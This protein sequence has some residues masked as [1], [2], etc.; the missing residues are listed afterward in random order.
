MFLKQKKDGKI[1]GLTVAGG[2]KHRDYI[3][4]EDSISSTVAIESVLIS[5]IV[6]AKEDRNVALIDI[7]NAFIQT[8]LEHEKDM[9]IIKMRGILL[10]ILLDIAPD[11]Y[12]TYVTTYRSGIN[13]LITPFK[14]PF[15]EPW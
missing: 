5:F 7:P 6:D 9:A 10:G 13:Q 15:M 1:K 4:K 8:I 2:N 14:I 12:G 3:S 11:V